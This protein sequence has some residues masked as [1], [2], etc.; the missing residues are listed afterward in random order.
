MS[1][2]AACLRRLGLSQPEAAR[3]HGVRLDTVKSW[4]VGRNR[5][6]QGAWDELRATEAAI[7]DRA[8]A[9]REQWADHPSAVVEIGLAEADFAGRMAAAD[10]VL[11]LPFGSSVR[12]GDTE[13]VLAA[14]AARKS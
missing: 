13:A 8:E 2:Y 7:V 4:C 5:P 12:D 1:L 6:P 9:L 10:F 11:G 3:L 14:R